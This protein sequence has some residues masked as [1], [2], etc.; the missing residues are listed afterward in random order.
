MSDAQ[1]A[2]LPEPQVGQL[3]L[4]KGRPALVTAVLAPTVI[5]LITVSAVAAG[6]SIDEERHVALGAWTPA[7]PVAIVATPA[8]PA[9]DKKAK[10]STPPAGRG[11]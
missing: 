5:N 6:A 7:E 4:F 9:S 2:S 8:A 3:V 1:T 11:D 10:G